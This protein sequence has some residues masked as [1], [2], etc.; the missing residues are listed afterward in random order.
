[1]PRISVLLFITITLASSPGANGESPPLAANATSVPDTILWQETTQDLTG[2]SFRSGNGDTV[3]VTASRPGQWILPVRPI[4]V[5]VVPLEEER[6]GAD[7]AELL[8]R[9]AGLQIKRYGGLGGPAVPSIRG[10]TGSQITVMVDGV[11]LADAQDGTIDLS[12]LPLERFQA[13]E[14]YRG[15]TAAHHAGAGGAGAVNLVSRPA[16]GEGSSVRLFTGSY[17]DLGGRFLHGLSSKDGFRSALLLIHG[18]SID[19]RYEF[20]DHN[21]TFANLEDDFSRLRLN[22]QFEEWGGH[23]SGHWSQS[24]LNTSL[25]LGYFRKEGGRPGP[26]GFESLHAVRKITRADGRWSLAGRD[27]VWRLDLTA[28]QTREWLHD[29]AGE[30]GFDP[31]GTTM[32]I[33]DDLNARFRVTHEWESRALFAAI[34]Q[35]RLEAEGRRQWYLETFNGQNDPLR[36]RTSLSGYG[37]LR[38]ALP[39]L[40]IAILPAVR[41]QG[42]KDNF[43]PLPPLPWLP[44]ETLT[45]PHRADATS[46]SLSAIWSVWPQSLSLEAHAGRSVRWPTWVE[47][48]GYRGSIVGNRELE[49]EEVRTLDIGVRW[50]SSSG[51]FQQRVAV[52]NTRTENTIIFVQNSQ[53]T[54]QAFNIGSTESQG[55]EWEA[56][57][58]TPGDGSVSANLTWQRTRDLSDILAYHGKELPFLPPLEFALRWSQTV[59][60]W[61]WGTTLVHEG[62]NFRDRYN[63]EM[64]RAP[65]RSLVNLSVGH[66]WRLGSQGVGFAATLTGELI[67]LTDNDVY[68]VEGFPLPGRSFRLS[69]YLR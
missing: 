62:S 64:E 56:V 4:T 18:R 12:S 34:W 49:P 1:M 63:I 19:N 5:T 48:F 39:E 38:F 17:G 27:D 29:E 57:L 68:D 47:L 24:A 11:P 25:S 53:R 13:A 50:Q 54:S 55:V 8:A 41:W 14:V 59:G 43:P 31:P 20:R 35:W 37:S 33:S 9:T 21:Q 2:E 45:Q 51:W 28:V 36:V 26:L 46:P 65:A 7:L 42:V 15:A 3:V 67:N 6:G 16:G 10:S 60:P 32:S 69:L 52:F 66:T 44:E 40:R 58:P 30:V 23:L 61:R 22:A